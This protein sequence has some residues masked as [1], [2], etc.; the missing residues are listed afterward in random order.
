[1]APRHGLKKMAGSRQ[2]RAYSFG[3]FTLDVDRKT[4]VRAAEKVDLDPKSLAALAYLAEHPG[5]VVTRDEFTRAT[6]GH[7]AVTDSTLTQC[8]NEIRR[9]LGDEGEHMIRTSSRGYLFDVA[10]TAHHETAARSP[11]S[12]GRGEHGERS[13]AVLPFVNTSAEPEQDYFSD[14]LAEELID[15]LA[16]NPEL[17]VASR[18]SAFQFKNRTADLST[19]AR[20]LGV[21][22]VLEGSVRR[23]GNAIRVTVRLLEAQTGAQLWS[24]TYE[25]ALGNVFAMQDDI[26]ATVFKALDVTLLGAVASRHS[27]AA[28]AYLRYLEARRLL[29]MHRP[30]AVARAKELLDEAVTIDPGFA[31]G[32][33]ELARAHGRLGDQQAAARYARQAA[34]ND[35]GNPTVNVGMHWAAL[36]DDHD[37]ARSASHLGRAL[38]KDPTNIEV[39]RAAVPLLNRLG[40]FSEAASIARWVLERDPMCLVCRVNLGAAYVGAE[41]FAEAEQA[42]RVALALAPESPHV[43]AYLA[44]SQLL[45]G[46]P[47]RAL[48]TLEDFTDPHPAFPTLR[49]LSLR[50]LGDLD[51]LPRTL[52]KLEREGSEQAFYFLAIAY[53]MKGDRDNAFTWLERS[54]EV[55]SSDVLYP[56]FTPGLGPLHDD[57]RWHAFLERFGLL[58]ELLEHIPLHVVMPRVGDRSRH[59]ESS[60]RAD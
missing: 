12:A 19:I 44:W 55:P 22:H 6:W 45:D 47:R 42:L 58:P 54:A 50:E 60:Q 56:H 15:L 31:R 57:P 34:A 39:L 26:A 38:A 30:E 21:S 41:R 8:L 4:L 9:A 48:S 17:E 37:L 28:A 25:R 24:E 23:S 43:R 32:W 1:M 20:E 18:T 16:R 36:V 46:K 59:S 52:A 7:T 13:I 53:A 3:E 10:V 40:R 14:G 2:H 27:P 33:A 35:P 11:E 49:A 29:D 51:I 5:R